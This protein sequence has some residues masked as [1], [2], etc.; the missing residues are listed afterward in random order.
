M[1]FSLVTLMRPG[2]YDNYRKLSQT[3]F[4]LLKSKIVIVLLA[5]KTLYFVST[6]CLKLISCDSCRQ[7]EKVNTVLRN[8]AEKY[9]E[10]GD[11]TNSRVKTSLYMIIRTIC[12]R[13]SILLN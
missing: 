5:K 3:F 12:C 7:V 9:V 6:F 11:A 13:M 4:S 8:M 1:L 10:L 2:S